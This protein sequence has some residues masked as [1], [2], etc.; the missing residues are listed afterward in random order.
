MSYLGIG[1]SATEPSLGYLL[2][3]AQGYLFTAPWY[4]AFPAAAI[5]LLILGV[6]LLGE[7]V[8][9]RMGVGT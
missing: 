4:T 5:V 8:R 2:K 3:D 1:V 7:G 6:S 9:E